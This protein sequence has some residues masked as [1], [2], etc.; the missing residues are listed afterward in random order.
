[1]VMNTTGCPGKWNVKISPHTY[2]LGESI[3]EQAYSFV[4][5]CIPYLPQNEKTWIQTNWGVSTLL[6]RLDCSIINPILDDTTTGVTVVKEGE[7]K[8]YELEPRP[9]GFGITR[10]FNPKFKLLFDELMAK[11]PYF[12]TLISPNRIYCDDVECLNEC[13][14]PKES[15]VLLLIRAEPE[16]KDFHRYISRSIAP[17][18][19]KGNKAYGLPEGMDL[20]RII[21]PEELEPGNKIWKKPFCVKPD[22]S[23]AE[24]VLMWHP[25]LS[26]E[27]KE[28][29][30]RNRKERKNIGIAS[31]KKIIDT[32]QKYG[33]MYHQEFIPPMFDKESGQWYIFRIFFGYDPIEKLWKYL[34]GFWVRRR[35][36]VI[37]GASDS[38]H[39][40]V[41]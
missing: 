1:M 32:I 2:V 14:N 25:N 5:D 37:H 23:K 30:P 19:E 31:Q 38:M 39:G 33:V 36:F 27:Y 11:W 18:R 40:P 17:V 9:S 24:G 15:E 7:L 20:W 21:H 35:N 4:K 28:W 12:E 13:K 16:E 6:I 41:Y 29:K 34:G 10:W 3:I 26:E 22:G 8:I